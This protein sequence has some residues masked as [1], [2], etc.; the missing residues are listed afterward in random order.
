[1]SL[2]WR[3]PSRARPKSRPRSRPKQPLTVLEPWPDQERRDESIRPELGNARRQDERPA[4]LVLVLLALVQLAPLGL[5]LVQPQEE[6]CEHLAR[7][8]VV[9]LALHREHPDLGFG[10]GDRDGRGRVH[11][12][13]WADHCA[14]CWE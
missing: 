5:D 3:A 9:R 8:A 2:L 14:A 1:M 7:K 10:L 12:D 4:D 13:G 11:D 6:E